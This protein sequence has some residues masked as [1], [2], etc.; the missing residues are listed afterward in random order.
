MFKIST[1]NF[2]GDNQGKRFGDVARDPDLDW[3]RWIDW[4]NHEERQERLEVAERHF[5]MPA[6]AGILR[7]LESEQFAQD[8]FKHRTPKETHRLNQAMGVLVRLHMEAR[9]WSTTGIKG[10]LGRRSDKPSIQCGH[11]TDRSFS[12]YFLSAERYRKSLDS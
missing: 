11:N 2:L 8:Y 5:D 3:G 4:L 6:L 1:V 10:P 7:E 9:G 12:K